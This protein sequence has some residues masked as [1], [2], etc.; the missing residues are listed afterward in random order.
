MKITNEELSILVWEDSHSL[1]YEKVDTFYLYSSRHE[2][3][4]EL[5]F[6]DIE[7]EFYYSVGYSE[8]VKDSMGWDECNFQNEYECTRVVPTEVTTITYKPFKDE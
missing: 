4:W 3:H 7:T 6:Q 5:I 2:E 8:S 1:P